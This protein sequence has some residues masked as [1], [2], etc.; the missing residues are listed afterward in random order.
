MPGPLSPSG[1]LVAGLITP[2]RFAVFAVDPGGV[3]GVA[4]GIFESRP[5]LKET[6]RVSSAGGSVEAWEVEGPSE[7]QAHEIAEEFLDWSASLMIDGYCGAPDIS[8]AFE[9]FALRQRS[10]DL[11]PVEVTWGVRT[12]LTPRSSARAGTLQD[13]AGGHTWE[14]QS[15]S[16]AKGFATSARLKTWELYKLGRGSDHKRDALR[17]LALRVSRILG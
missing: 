14:Y 7:V 17:H 13:F 4:R 12:L 2:D 1:V 3:T 9:A 15:P 8:L 11:A 10:V 5:T 16:D 6:L